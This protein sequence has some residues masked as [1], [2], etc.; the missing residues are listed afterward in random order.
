MTT[1]ENLSKD[2][3]E[4]ISRNIKEAD[5]YKGMHS[6]KD[7]L[8]ITDP[9]PLEN[10]WA[11]VGDGI[12]VASLSGWGDVIMSSTIKDILCNN[13]KESIAM[14]DDKLS[15]LN[16][17]ISFIEEIV[18]DSEKT[19]IIENNNMVLHSYLT[20]NDL[21]ITD[22]QVPSLCQ[23]DMAGYIHNTMRLGSVL[24]IETSAYGFENLT[25]SMPSSCGILIV[26]KNEYI[27]IWEWTDDKNT[28]YHAIFNAATSLWS[29]WKLETQKNNDEVNNQ[30]VYSG[31]TSTQKGKSV[32]IRHGLDIEKI[33]GVNVIVNNGSYIVLPH[34][35][36]VASGYEYEIFV[37]SENIVIKNSASNSGNILGKH[38]NVTLSY[39]P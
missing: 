13:K 20:Y 21:G 15:E 37:D 8:E 22:H 23:I 33:T 35:Y 19:Q 39:M 38:F 31:K 9:N 14:Y 29:G 36:L 4:S 18:H 25:K 10:D 28:K 26:V 7:A 24:S 2:V 30:K 6:D 16:E 3:S 5:K 17:K 1:Y 34:H 32:E 12:C 27:S 11:I